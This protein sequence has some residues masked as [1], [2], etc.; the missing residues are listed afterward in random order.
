MS[1]WIA[2]ALRGVSWRAPFLVMGSLSIVAALLLQFLP[3]TIDQKTPEF[4]QSEVPVPE[5]PEKVLKV[6]RNVPSRSRTGQKLSLVQEE[7]VDVGE[8]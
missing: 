5:K 4:L 1:P 8:V 7:D 2:D 3:E 6:G